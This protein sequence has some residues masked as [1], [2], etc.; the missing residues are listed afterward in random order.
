MR[1][2]KE[3]GCRI[4]VRN[5]RCVDP[6]EVRS[7]DVGHPKL[8]AFKAGSDESNV[9]LKVRYEFTEPLL[10]VG[11]CGACCDNSHDVQSE[12]P[13]SQRQ[14]VDLSSH[15]VIGDEDVGRLDACEVECFRRGSA[16]DRN[17]IK[18]L[19]K[20]R[21]RDVPVTAIDKIRMDL[22]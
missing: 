10:A 12:S 1:V 3:E 20:G 16:C 2:S 17:S 4:F 19:G 13:R 8:G 14:L 22:V 6:Q 21:D 5:L 9:A 15:R 7:F 11:V 18:F